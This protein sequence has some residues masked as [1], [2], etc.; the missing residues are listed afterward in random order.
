MASTVE[1]CNMAL[2]RVGDKRIISLDDGTERADLC[3]LLYPLIRREVLRR[4]HWASAKSRVQLP[5]ASGTPANGYQYAYDLPGD[6]IHVR[7]VVGLYRTDWARE[8][9]QILTDRAAPIEI[10]YTRDLDDAEEADP[11][12]ANVLASRLAV[13]ISKRLE[14][15]HTAKDFLLSELNDA[16]RVAKSQDAIERTPHRLPDDS[17]LLARWGHGLTAAHWADG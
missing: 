17:W 4:Y 11:L 9:R 14:E 12:L 1:I 2:T 10:L 13:E 6:V 8:G 16:L 5:A 15:S 7:A 3:K